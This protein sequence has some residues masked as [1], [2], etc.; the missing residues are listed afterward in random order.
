M[1]ITLKFNLEL[2]LLIWVIY[3]ILIINTCYSCC[4]VPKVFEMYKTI[5]DCFR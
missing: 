1:D 2:I 3:L 4:D 5:A